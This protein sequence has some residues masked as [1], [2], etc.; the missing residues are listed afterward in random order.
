MVGLHALQGVMV[1]NWP[2]I[3]SHRSEILRGLVICWC[4]VLEDDSP[5]RATSLEPVRR[6]I[7]R[8]ALLLAA[9]PGR[10]FDATAEYCSVAASD[11]RLRQLLAM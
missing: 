9:L 6:E 5:E 2:C 7:R 8:S 1:N 10:E 11:D 4:K 3:S